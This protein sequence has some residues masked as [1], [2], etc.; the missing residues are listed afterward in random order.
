[1]SNLMSSFQRSFGREDRQ[2]ISSSIRVFTGEQ[3]S[4]LRKVSI[5]FLHLQ[6]EERRLTIESTRRGYLAFV[7]R[8][9]NA[10]FERF[11]HAMFL[12]FLLRQSR[13]FAITNVRQFPAFGIAVRIT[14]AKQRKIVD[15]RQR[16]NPTWASLVNGE[17][18]DIVSRRRDTSITS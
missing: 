13:L 7:V 12:R 15:L 4:T 8:F 5:G 18:R 14:R 2:S 10:F 6:S 3:R 1:M 11:V 16:R 17:C 9:L